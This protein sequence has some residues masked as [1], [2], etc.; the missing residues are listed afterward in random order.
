M[1]D[2]NDLLE[3]AIEQNGSDIYK[4]ESDVSAIKDELDES[5]K[6]ARYDITDLDKRITKIR[7]SL[8]DDFVEYWQFDESNIE[9]KKKLSALTS[10][11]ADCLSQVRAIAATCSD[12]KAEVRELKRTLRIGLD[13]REERLTQAV[14]D[15]MVYKK[16]IDLYIKMLEVSVSSE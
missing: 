1:S 16:Q 10:E 5:T 8:D 11:V 12:L 7:K 6:D 3:K 4:L 9:I 2:V 15:M 14:K 13:D